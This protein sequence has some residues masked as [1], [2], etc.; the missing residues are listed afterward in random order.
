MKKKIDISH[1]LKLHPKQLEAYRYIGKGHYLFFGGARGGGKTRFSLITAILVARQFPGITVVVIRRKYSEL[2]EAFIHQ[3]KT[4]YPG[5]I[6]G[7]KYREKHRVA[8]F[9]NGARILFR[10]C[11]TESDTQKIQGIEFQLMIIDE[12]NN[13]DEMTLLRLTGSLRKSVD[14]KGLRNFIPSL[15]M[16]GNP[17][18][19][20]DLYFKTRFINPDYKYWRAGELAHKD[21]YIFVKSMMQDNP[22]L[23]AEEYKLKLGDLPYNLREAWLN[24]NW[25]VFQ[26]QFFEEWNEEAHV[27]PAFDIPRDWK[28][29]TGMD[30]GF[31]DKHPT[32][33][34]WGAQ[35]PK[36]H[37]VHIYKEAVLTGD[38]ESQAITIRNMQ[39]GEH[40]DMQ[41]ADPSMWDDT[42]KKKIGDDSAAMI[43][44]KAGLPL[45][46]ADNSR[47]NGW[48]IVKQWMHWGKN[49]KP[50]LRIHDTCYSLISALP[51][52][53]YNTRAMVSTED[54]DTTQKYD[55]FA[56]ALRYLLKSGFQYPMDYNVIDEITERE[57]KEERPNEL[58]LQEI[59]ARAGKLE[60]DHEKEGEE[61]FYFKDYQEI[62]MES[63]YI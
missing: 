47:I 5:Q 13:F 15:I 55:D 18:G 28:K 24:G 56:D 51:T 16:T 30:L 32:V 44:L 9:D 48:R 3:I 19:T 61:A 10:A 49:R 7:Y 34:L 23:D 35:D 26:G 52:L 53:K 41:L 1:H 17:G 62:S 31:T 57:N 50:K 12:A 8:L 42:T 33:M 29:I 43:Y 39:E 4:D 40:I 54:L 14:K 63:N 46:K 11:D 58:S 21:K 27:I 38:V 37:E 25:N 45:V 59:M 2:E 20:S 36:T 6:F 22:S 60:Y